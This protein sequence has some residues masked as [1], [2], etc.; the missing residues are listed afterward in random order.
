MYPYFS[1]T[2]II[3]YYT[4]GIGC[5]LWLYLI[6]RDSVKAERKLMY[7]LFWLFLTLF[8]G[9]RYVNDFGI[10]GVDAAAY[11]YFFEHPD[12]PTYVERMEGLYVLLNQTIAS[13]SSDPEI[14][15]IICCGI[16]VFG[17]VFV[18]YKFSYSKQLSVIPFILLIFPYLRSFNTVRSSLAIALFLVGI[19]YLYEKKNLLACIFIIATVL[20]HRMSIAYVMVIPFY[21]IFRSYNFKSNNRIFI[22]LS[23]YIILSYT[24]ALFAQSY[25]LSAGLLDE[26]DVFYLTSGQGKSPLANVPM[27]FG[28]VMIFIALV[29]WNKRLPDTE[30]IS[31]I[32]LM[33][34]FD[35]II[36]PATLVLGMWRALEYMYIPRL[37]M[38]GYLIPVIGNPRN[39]D[40]Q[41]LVKFGMFAAF[42]FWLIFRIYKEWEPAGLTP[43]LTIFQ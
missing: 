16:I 31:F 35:I 32:R 21:Y 10:G 19:V 42:S 17:Y 39:R 36:I 37:I 8:G 6:N 12:D 28:H 25:V 11:Q 23:V 9:L 34:I 20:V 15:R 3:L 4:V 30:E 14:F 2:S 26:H 7:G 33:V 24:V 29:L 27:V 41:T 38:W 22:F 5:M 1:I 40:S 13:F 18:L 43:Y